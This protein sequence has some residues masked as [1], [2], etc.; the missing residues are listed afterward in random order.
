MS[1]CR[2]VSQ[3]VRIEMAWAYANVP[4]EFASGTQLSE[5][6]VNY[7]IDDDYLGC[8]GVDTEDGRTMVVVVTF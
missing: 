7:E 3:D 2:K 1:T 8:G 5:R 4:E 6:P